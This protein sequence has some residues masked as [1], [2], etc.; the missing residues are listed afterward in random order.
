MAKT[1]ARGM[2]NIVLISF[3][4]AMLMKIGENYFA[5]ELS[6]MLQ[7]SLIFDL[8][9]LF[10]LMIYTYKIIESISP[11]ASVENSSAQWAIFFFHFHAYLSK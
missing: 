2:L 3:P 4:S 9:W 8:I 7:A 5:H 6:R 1:D 10:F 11:K